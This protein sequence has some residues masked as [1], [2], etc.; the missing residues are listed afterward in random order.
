MSDFSDFT[1]SQQY[2]PAPENASILTLRD[3]YDLYIDGSWVEPESGEY[4]DSFNPATGDKLAEVARA[5]EADVDAAV[6]AARAAYEGE[7][8]RMPAVERGKI[9][10]RLARI[11]QECSRELAVLETLDGGKPI[12]ES[13]D[14]DLP[15]VASH[16]FYNAGWADKLE[17]AF[18][19]RSVRSLGVCGQ[20]IP[21]FGFIVSRFNRRSGFSSWGSEY[22]LW[23]EFNRGNLS[24]SSRCRQSRFHWL[25]GCRKTNPTPAR[26]DA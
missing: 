20:V 6:Q 24:E 11:I 2:A 14:I 17:F 26:W 3:R 8:G 5:N 19:G 23:W 10:F 16:F 15:L 22:C 13:R 1:D 4:F 25:Y 18:P 21:W 9:L 12:R 7:W